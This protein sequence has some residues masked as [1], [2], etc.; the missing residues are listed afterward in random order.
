MI[1]RILRSFKHEEQAYSSCAGILHSSKEVPHAVVEEAAEHCVKANA[2]RNKYFKKS[3]QY[4]EERTG[5]GE[6]PAGP[7]SEACE[8][9]REGGLSMRHEDTLTVEVLLVIG[10]LRSIRLLKIGGR[11]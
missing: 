10:H 5:C 2:C 3:S 9:S 4:R 11:F 7:P 1:D 6:Y 8:H